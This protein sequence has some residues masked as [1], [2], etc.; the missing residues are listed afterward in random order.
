MNDDTPIFTVENLITSVNDVSGAIAR[1]LIVDR[2]RL[3]QQ[4]QSLIKRASGSK[5]NEKDAQK[6]IH[7]LNAS[8]EKVAKRESSFSDISYPQALPISEHREVICAAIA[9]HQVVVIA[10]ETGSGKT[11][12]IPKFCAELGRG[13]Y[14]RIGHTQPRRLAARTVAARIAEELEVKLGEEVGYQFRFNEQVID[15]TRIKVMTDG[16]LLAEIQKDRWLNQYDTLI[17]DEA[18]ERSLNIDFLLGYLKMLL[19]KRSELKL[20]VTSATIDVARFSEF[21]DNAP[22]IE[23]AGRTFPVEINYA[24]A[25]VDDSATNK[26]ENKLSTLATR[27]ENQAKSSV[28]ELG[29]DLPSRICE[30][31]ATIHQQ[32][33]VGKNGGPRDVLIFLPGE[34]EIRDVS[35]SIKNENQLYDVLPL[36]ARLSQAEQQRIFDSNRRKSGTIRRIVLATNVAE[37]S[38]TVP[39]IGYVIDSGLARISRFSVRS[40]LQRLPIEAI[41]RASA[42]QRAGRCGRIAPGVCYRLYEE[43]D[44]LQR[45]EFTEPELLRTNLASVILQMK[46]LNLGAIEQF[47]FLHK[48][49]SRQISAGVKTLHDIGALDNENRLNQLG[50]S[51]ASLP[52]DPR[53]G[54]MLLASIN[55]HC[56]E[57][58]LIIVSALA[59]QDPKE[60]PPDKQQAADQQHRRF[61]DIDSDFLSWINLWRYCET[62]RE[63]LSQNQW[64]KRCKKEFL[65]YLRLREWR[66]VHRQLRL[67]I[68]PLIQK[69]KDSQTQKAETK[70]ANDAKRSDTQPQNKNEKA[71]ECAGDFSPKQR[72]KIHRALITGL[73]NNIGQKESKGEYRGARNL[74][75]FLFPTSSVFK[76]SPNWV[77]AA[78][79]VETKKVYARC[80]AKIDPLW[81]CKE[82]PHLVK[83]QYSEPHW[84]SRR[85]QVMALR[86]TSLFGLVLVAKQKVA[87]DT[88][89]HEVAR[90]IFIQQALVAEQLNASS[91]LLQLATFF[92]HNQ[93][94]L[95]E[96]KQLEE[97]L[98]RRDLLVDDEALYRFYHQRLDQ[99]IVSR[100]RLQDWLTSAETEAIN[101]LQ[102]TQ[103]DIL[104]VS[105]SPD[106]QAQLPDQLS[107]PECTLDLE[108][109]FLPGAENDGV[110][111]KIPLGVLNS[112]PL[113]AFDWLVPGMLRD[114]C[115]DLI[116][117][118]PKAQRKKLVPVPTVVDQLLARIDADAAQ[119]Q[120]IPLTHT[121]SEQIKIHHNTHIEPAEW[122]QNGEKTLDG[123][124][125]MRFEIIDSEGVGLHC[126]R[127][128]PELQAL[129]RDQLNQSIDAYA[130]DGFRRQNLL[131]WSFG[132]LPER[133][134]YEHDGAIL[135]G[136]PVLV[137]KTDSVELDLLSNES[138][139]IVTN[140]GGVVRLL[141]LAMKDKVRYLKK[142]SCRDAKKILPFV[143]IGSKEQ[144]IDD[145]IKSAVIASC[146]DD[147]TRPLP[148]DQQQFEECIEHGASEVIAVANEIE[149]QLT[150]SLHYYHQICEQLQKRRP[151]FRLQS[152]DIDKQMAQLMPPGFLQLIGYRRLLHLPRYLQAIIVRLDRLNGGAEL[153]TQLCEKLR[154]VE[155]PLESLLYKYP[156]AVYHDV[157]VAD[158]RWLLEE[159][160]V[161]L[162]AQQLKTPVPVSLQR[163]VKAWKKINL[164][165]YPLVNFS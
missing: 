78:E 12:Q 79:I 103:N 19:R 158:Y 114:K 129:C 116:K 140:R 131:D 33:P 75:F 82:L 2:F 119:Q 113:Y 7:R 138:D 118:L 1:S 38:I 53:L 109:C 136:F 98:R 29:V 151:F 69:K 44:F 128:I 9:S 83:H 40:K 130:D 4:Y 32:D 156:E 76:S 106:S 62:Q 73:A 127:S 67:A 165:H 87:Y 115:I 49:D 89:D 97:K 117:L 18:H 100:K 96:F 143:R 137:D 77:M 22:I 65:S 70:G 110:T 120:N 111:A 43:A 71:A 45:P 134:Q 90:R 16:I 142:T 141:M 11:T 28:D 47:P 147:F 14:G 164:N 94:L 21:F 54:R 56:V 99:S 133:H 107:L 42:N 34:R 39:G 30:V 15:E 36:Y 52:V 148:R 57:E 162:F 144:L 50:K 5:T 126:G 84:D 150:A 58:M 146:L 60:A 8:L 159:L 105:E 124:C 139:A 108:Y 161:S 20:I 64:R 102:L 63:E 48:P 51:L 13:I 27:Q 92:T 24:R 41:S 104:L 112:V 59:V 91:G 152:D 46:S 154:S 80:N 68:K 163:V 88:I 122:R 135:Q 31:L 23:I 145:L 72:E 121:L 55:H 66:D 101:S 35:R 3:T 157:A 86:S 160:R 125:R 85:G 37:T 74:R 149:S 123:Y 61:Y 17:I 93:G 132:P 153:D 6:F 155:Q 95:T 25:T 81:V 26:D 10:G